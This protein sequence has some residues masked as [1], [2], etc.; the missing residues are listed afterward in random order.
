MK[1][2]GIF[3]NC[4]KP[5]APEV[6]RKAAALAKQHGL[7]IAACDETARLVP[8]AKS[9]APAD[10]IESIDILMAFGGDGTMLNAVRLLNGRDIPVLGVNLGSLGFLTSVS[11][12]D[13]EHAIECLAGGQFT[14]SRRAMV[15]CSIKR[16]SLEICRHRALNDI[17]IDRGASLRIVTLNMAIEG[18]DVSSFVCDGL[19]VSTPTGSTGHSLSAGGPILH[20][21]SAVFVISLV[22]PHT[23]SMR[24]LVIPDNKLVAVEVAKSAGDLSLSVDG[25]I[26]EPLKIADR[27]EIRR[28]AAHVRFVHLPDYSYFSVLRHK[29]QWRGSTSPAG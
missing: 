6:L 8:E 5:S 21:E 18:E 28:G 9:F 4:Q 29:L 19:I 27:I 1:T 26:G 23:L 10:F 14:T 16:K 3:A 22:C 24:P 7:K 13:I 15:E 20:P 2:I 25:Q 17:V 12:A 11:Q